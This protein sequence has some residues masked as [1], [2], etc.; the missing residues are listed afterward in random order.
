MKR[1]CTAIFL[2]LSLLLSFGCSSIPSGTESII[3]L[4]KKGA[5]RLGQNVIVVGM[6]DSK[7]PLSSFRMLKVYQNEEFIWVTLPEGAE[8]PPQGVDIRVTGALQQKEFN[9]IGKVLYIEATK[10]AME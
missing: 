6:A 8:E 2:V 9:I 5:E 10:V 4:Q 3:E 1:L 7:T